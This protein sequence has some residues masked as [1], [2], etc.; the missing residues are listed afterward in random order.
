MDLGLTD[1]VYVVTGGTRGLGL[2]TA[3]ALVAEGAR[4]VVAGR[5]PGGGRA[6]RR[7]ARPWRRPAGRRPRRPGGSRA[8]WSPPPT[9]RTAASTVP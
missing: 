6:G 3:Q 4:V 2:A 5:E 8:D 9:T 1:K 7:G